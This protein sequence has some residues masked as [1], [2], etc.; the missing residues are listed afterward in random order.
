MKKSPSKK[1][2]KLGALYNPNNH[3]P[4]MIQLESN[5]EKPAGIATS[6]GVAQSML[7]LQQAKVHSNS[8]QNLN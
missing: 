8:T 4:R 5:Y 7:E 2:S 1:F 6:Y 3:D